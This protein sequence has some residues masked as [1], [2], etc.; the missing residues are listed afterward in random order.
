MIDT[1]SKLTSL[2]GR[3]FLLAGLLPAAVLFAGIDLHGGTLRL[4]TVNFWSRGAFPDAAVLL[5]AWSAVGLVLFAL[6]PLIVWLV[7]DVPGPWMSQ[8]RRV[9][10]NRQIARRSQLLRQKLELE[11]DFTALQWFKH[12]YSPPKYQRRRMFSGAPADVLGSSRRA[13][14]ALVNWADRPVIDIPREKEFSVFVS[15]LVD[16]HCAASSFSVGADILHEVELWKNQTKGPDARNV[17]EAISGEIHRRWAITVARYRA[18]PEGDWI[19]PTVFGNR[20][21][22][23]DDYAERRYGIDTATI[24]SRLYWVLPRAERAEISDGKLATEVCLN[25]CLVFT[26]LITV[27]GIDVALELKS[28]TSI[29]HQW[30]WLAREAAYIVGLLALVAGGYR[31]A[32]LAADALVDRMVGLVDIH[33]LAVLATQGY[34]PA[35]IAEE[36]EMCKELQ[37]F[38]AQANERNPDRTLGFH[39]K[40]KSD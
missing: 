18:F 34:V 27:I 17:L 6:R 30:K 8:F 2:L 5:L 26:V 9:L 13:R 15:G 7:Q 25:L 33:R 32:I 3:S 28:P 38:F 10:I 20:L 23:L 21:A 14:E 19:R 1:F 39:K 35:T 36:K 37:G 31:A 40:P 22:A 11:L 4:D 29:L 16:L 24:W 12:D